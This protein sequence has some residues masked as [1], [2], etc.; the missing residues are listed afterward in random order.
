MPGN[1]YAARKWRTNLQLWRE[2]HLTRRNLLIVAGLILGTLLLVPFIVSTVISN[3]TQRFIVHQL[4][5]ITPGRAGVVIGINPATDLTTLRQ[6]LRLQAA[7]AITALD[8]ARIFELNIVTTNPYE[9]QIDPLAKIVVLPNIN[10]DIQL[11]KELS[12]NDL[13]KIIIFADDVDLGRVLFVC[14]SM[15]I[16]AI[17]LPLN[18]TNPLQKLTGSISNTWQTMVNLWDLHVRGASVE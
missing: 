5:N 18:L 6:Q 11:C 8:T 14:R 16:D 17:G 1:Q 2:E 4:A 12:A 9:Y 10:N 7:P 15:G 13:D 3:D